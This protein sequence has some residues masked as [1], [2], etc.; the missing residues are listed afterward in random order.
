VRHER[1][2]VLLD[3]DSCGQADPAGDVGTFL[4]TLRQRTLR[5]LLARRSTAAGARAR[6]ALAEVFLDEYVEAAGGGADV[7]LR[8]RIAWYE[9]VALERKALRCFARAPRSPLTRALVEQGHAR[10]DRL[11]G[12]R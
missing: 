12:I 10:L 2:V 1:E 8:R 4:A 3:L 11:G 6:S 9:A 5:Q 7:E